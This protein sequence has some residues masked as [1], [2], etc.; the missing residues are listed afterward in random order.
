MLEAVAQHMEQARHVAG[1]VE[2]VAEL[3]NGVD[4]VGIRKPRPLLGLCPLD[5]VNQRIDEQPELW[6]ICIFTF[7]ISARRREQSRFDIGFKAFF[8]DFVNGHVLLPPNVMSF[9]RILLGL[10]LWI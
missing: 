9:Y 10:S 6:I 5:K 4:L 1:I 7:D 3:F 2:G 8:V